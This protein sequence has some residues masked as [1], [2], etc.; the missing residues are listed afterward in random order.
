M[1]QSMLC[2]V[3]HFTNQIF[4]DQ[5]INRHGWITEWAHL[6]SLGHPLGGASVW[7]DSSYF[8]FE[9]VEI[10]HKEILN[11]SKE[12]ENAKMETQQAEKDAKYN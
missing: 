1:S 2:H 9:R 3:V 7:T 12:R 8:L 6:T 10:D 4:S 5:N 11:E